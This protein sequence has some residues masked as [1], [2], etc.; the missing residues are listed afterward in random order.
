MNKIP[1][2]LSE[3]DLFVA[4]IKAVDQAIQIDQLPSVT[5][6][7]IN[8][9][10]IQN[11][12]ST[13]IFDQNN[14]YYREIFSVLCNSLYSSQVFNCDSSNGSELFF[15]LKFP[16]EELIEFINSIPVE[17]SSQSFSLV[18][19]TIDTSHFEKLIAQVGVTMDQIRQQKDINIVL[20]QKRAELEHKQYL[21][22]HPNEISNEI[23][24]SETNY[25]LLM[26]TEKN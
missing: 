25:Q 8:K 10:F 21:L 24:N 20:R 12:K 19:H 13:S 23:R 1:I 22:A 14:T 3:R 5:A 6:F 7:Q 11:R 15:S 18:S 2:P 9:I 26:Q 16:Q 4:T 17:D